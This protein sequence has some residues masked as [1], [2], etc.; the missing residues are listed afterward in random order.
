M[1]YQKRILFFFTFFL[2]IAITLS[3]VF[4]YSIPQAQN[5]ASLP[6]YNIM[7]PLWS[8]PLVTD[9]NWD[10]LVLLGTTPIIT[11]LS[12]TTVLPVQ[13]ALAWNIGL[14]HPWAMYNIPL[15][16]GG[17]LAFFD[18]TYGFNTFP[19]PSLLD[20]V[21]SLPAPVTLPLGWSLYLP[22][23]LKGFEY[24]IPLANAVYSTRYGVP[25]SSL[26][27]SADIWGLPPI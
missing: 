6:P 21:T 15:T 5:W 23:K 19:P 18:Q 24:F 7:W 27:T 20:P 9:F 8:P 4:I 26:L 16:F 22:T 12:R 10:P 13:P 11:E 25:I 14:D 1:I 2:F 3:G 17:G